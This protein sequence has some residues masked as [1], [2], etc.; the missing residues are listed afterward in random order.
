MANDGL[1][2]QKNLLIGFYIVSRQYNRRENNY[3]INFEKILSKLQ[4]IKKT[5]QKLFN[6]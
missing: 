6:E 1:E 4:F 3:K 2:I 5:A